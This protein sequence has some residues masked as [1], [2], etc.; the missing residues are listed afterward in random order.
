M[1]QLMSPTNVA[2]YVQVPVA[3]VYRWRTHG[4]GPHGFRV[5][6]HVRYRREDVDAWLDEQRNKRGSAA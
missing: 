6:K 4:E 5:G 2:E 1:E 3:T